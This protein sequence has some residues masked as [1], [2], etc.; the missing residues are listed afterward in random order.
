MISKFPDSGDFSE[1]I[2]HEVIL[3]LVETRFS[4]G[5]ELQYEEYSR[6]LRFDKGHPCAAS[7]A[8]DEE[9]ID[10]IIRAEIE[11]TLNDEHKDEIAK[12][13]R[14]GSNYGKALVDSGIISSNELLDYN[15]TQ[16][17]L[18]FSGALKEIP[19]SYSITEQESSKHNPLKLNILEIVRQSI[20]NDLRDIEVTSKLDDLELVYIPDDGIEFSGHESI[21]EDEEIKPI[22]SHLKDGKSASDVIGKV[23]LN[24]ER[25]RR[26]FLFLKLV[27]WIKVTEKLN[28]VEDDQL[29]DEEAE[30]LGG[31][32]IEEKSEDSDDILKL[33][34]EDETELYDVDET[35]PEMPA[36]ADPNEEPDPDVMAPGPEPEESFAEELIKK[37]SRKPSLFVIGIVSMAALIV[38]GGI[39]TFI[40]WP[41]NNNPDEDISFYDESMDKEQ[42]PLDQDFRETTEEAPDQVEIKVTEA[43]PE[44]Q[45]V[46]KVEEKPEEKAPTEE[47]TPVEEKTEPPVEEKKPEIKKPEPEPRELNS[48]TWEEAQPKALDTGFRQNW[49]KASYIW[50]GPLSRTADNQFTI[51]ITSSTT[52]ENVSSVF[53]EFANSSRLR[54][55]FF[56]VYTPDKRHLILWGVFPSRNSARVAMANF[57]PGIKKYQPQIRSVASL[58]PKK[59]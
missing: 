47:T 42:L 8:A 9:Q 57:P 28:F 25:T 51:F 40:L 18:I 50:E 17:K 6:I 7:S 32:E 23:G 22:V 11:P 27:G 20:L 56:V 44:P 58:K 29:E 16:A 55:R 53:E 10:A 59:Q 1:F 30:D 43:K 52:N 48:Y 41:K 5:I 14:P 26:N 46:E 54:E 37:S 45:P 39:T 33:L 34:G 4:G 24:P 13:D 35:L 49:K 31:A 36:L 15:R 12:L 21:R 2:L 38:I 19:I 3:H